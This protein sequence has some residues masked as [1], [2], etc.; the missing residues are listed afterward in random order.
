MI[1]FFFIS[2][3]FYNTNF[4]DNCSLLMTSFSFINFLTIPLKKSSAQRLT[5]P[6]IED[7]TLIEL[8]LAHFLSSL[9]GDYTIGN[10]CEDLIFYPCSLEY[11]MIVCEQACL[12][13]SGRWF[14]ISYCLEV[15]CPNISN[16]KMMFLLFERIIEVYLRSG[17]G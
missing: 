9:S 17:I 5:P 6:F 3:G 13:I 11:V 8:F 2:N 12:R 1:S 14:I 7:Y 16:L 10:I 4:V 15:V